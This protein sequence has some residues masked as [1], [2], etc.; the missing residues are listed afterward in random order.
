MVKGS[1]KQDVVG[2]HRARQRLLLVVAARVGGDPEAAWSSARQRLAAMHLALLGGGARPRPHVIPS[3]E[4]GWEGWIATPPEDQ[5]MAAVSK[6]REYILAGD[7]FQVVL[8]R[9]W[10]KMPRCTASE[11]Y[12]MLRLTNPSPYMFFLKLGD[13]HLVGASPEVMESDVTDVIEAAVNTIE[14]IKQLTSFSGAQT[15]PRAISP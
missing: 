14:G 9:R 8:S 2:T 4:G 11:I 3:S 12:R 13:L 10:R 1:G 6:A 5:Y 15:R 7:I